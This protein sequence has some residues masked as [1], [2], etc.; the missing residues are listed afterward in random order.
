MRIELSMDT[1]EQIISFL[2]RQQLLTAARTNKSIYNLIEFKFGSAPYFI[3]GQLSY[4]SHHWECMD[5]RYR[6]YESNFEQ[7]PF[8]KYLRS[9]A[10]YMV[11]ES[12]ENPME[13][14]PFVNHIWEDN[15]LRISWSADFRPDM[16]FGSLVSTC[17]CL[18]LDGPSS[19]SVIS[20]LIG[21]NCH[22]LKFR[23]SSSGNEDLKTF[24][25]DIV[26]FLYSPST[27]GSPVLCIQTNGRFSLDVFEELI[28]KIRSRFYASNMPVSL[29]FLWQYHGS[30][31]WSHLDFEMVNDKISQCLVLHTSPS[32][33]SLK[34]IMTERDSQ[35]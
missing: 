7:V 26:D 32:G 13:V 9:K 28:N 35:S 34:T 27:N 3:L 1:L 21:A 20:S 12:N 31:E 33:I 25:S 16:R 24:S 6:P 14:L 30:I 5:T 18:T 15:N 11:F 10:T 8:Y 29:Q 22:N 23:D 4:N 17:R 19:I 2:N